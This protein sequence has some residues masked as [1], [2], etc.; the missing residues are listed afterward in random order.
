VRANRTSRPARRLIALACL[1]SVL[2]L[3][4]VAC[5]D[6]DEPAATT[7]TAA[8]ET[9]TTATP[10]DGD[11][12]TGSATSV[13]TQDATQY[14]GQDG[15]TYDL[16]CTP[17]GKAD[18]VWGA[19]TYTDDSSICTAAVQSGLIT[20]DDGGSVT[21]EIAPGL[22]EYEAGT[23]NGVTST[24]YGAFEGSFTFPDAPPGSVDFALGPESWGRRG[25][26][27]RGRN[28]ETFSIGCAG[29]GPLGS[30]W[31][32]DTYTDDSSVCTA[33]VHSGLISVDEGGTVVIEIAP[34][35]SSYQGSSAHGVTTSDYGAFEGSFTFP[36][37]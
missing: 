16:D 18:A 21:Y 4:T 8:R 9:T 19:G 35:Q 28:G 26:D 20:F 3:G 17:D 14:R 31:G 33:A 37:T 7:T 11:G 27:Y 13:W 25:T 10:D 12:A 24:R 5:G 36:P 29:G 22:A 6:D 32:T 2:V 34:G 15:Q 1:S 23:A 30:A